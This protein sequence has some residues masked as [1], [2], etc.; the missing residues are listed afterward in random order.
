MLHLELPPD[1]LTSKRVRDVLRNLRDEVPVADE[2]FDDL[3]LLSTE[4]VTNSV[5]HAGLQ[6]GQF[7][8]FDLMRLRDR[9]RIEVTDSG[10][11][12]VAKEGLLDSLPADSRGLRIVATIGL[13]WGIYNDGTTTVWVELPAV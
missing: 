4:L 12:L 8:S 3:L 10:P 11:G 2:V 9:L 6:P 5:R 7:I 1:L 13:E